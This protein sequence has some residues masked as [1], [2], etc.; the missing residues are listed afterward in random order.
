MTFP[1]QP[2]N[3]Y[4]WPYLPLLFFLSLFFFFSYFHTYPRR[5]CEWRFCDGYG[6]MVRF[7]CGTCLQQPSSSPLPYTMYLGPALSRYADSSSG[8]TI[9]SLRVAFSNCLAAI[10]CLLFALEAAFPLP[11]FDIS[12]LFLVNTDES[13]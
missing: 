9:R 11:L 2:Y 3:R 1:L 5:V 13:A 7:E 6:N 12:H 10:G 4:P 8:T